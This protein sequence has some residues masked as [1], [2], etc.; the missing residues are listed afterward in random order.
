MASNPPVN[1]RVWLLP[2]SPHHRRAGEVNFQLQ[3][4][5]SPASFLPP[6]ELIPFSVLGVEGDRETMQLIVQLS[7]CHTH[8]WYG[9]SL[10][11]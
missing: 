4:L 3:A 8:I 10:F 1:S 6:Q 5:S 11:L 9:A 2:P 7:C